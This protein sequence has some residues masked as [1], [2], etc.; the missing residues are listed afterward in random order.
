M[1]LQIDQSTRSSYLNW[2]IFSLKN[3][4]KS[5]KFIKKEQAQP[6]SDHKVSIN[7]TCSMCCKSVIGNYHA[8]CTICKGYKLCMECIGSGMEKACHLR[9]HPFVI[10]EPDSRPVFRSNWSINEELLFLEAIM[11][12]GLGNWVDIA[13]L[14]DKRTAEECESHYFGTYLSTPE[15]P[16]PDFVLLG[17]DVII[18]RPDFDTAPIEPYPSDKHA[19]AMKENNKKEMGTPEILGFMPFREE[20]E[21]EY[22]DEAEELIC[23]LSFDQ[24]VE[25]PESFSHKIQQLSAY[26]GVIIERDLRCQVS[27]DWDF[28]EVVPQNS[29]IADVLLPFSPYIRNSQAIKECV[30]SISRL[31]ELRKLIARNLEW[32]ANGIQTTKE[33]FLYYELIK[34]IKN[35]KIDNVEQ[36]N[37]E[38]RNYMKESSSGDPPEYSLLSDKEIELCKRNCL[39]SQ[40][41]L[42]LKD[43]LIREFAIRG[44][45]TKEESIELSNE[46]YHIVEQIYD[47]FVYNGWICE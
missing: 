37:K 31:N 30:A 3:M 41:Y 44:G 28:F 25:T 35:D 22:L 1:T 21:T 11:K 5:N 10:V 4:S 18:P 47:M 24:K 29:Q 40:H 20:F 32:Q 45:L 17:P 39:D 2:V 12:E 43:L 36:W 13:K 23:D 46:N 6:D 34:H 38:I 8:L 15:T 14:C 42:A 27:V 26:H 19:N 9:D 16:K 7:N 33:G